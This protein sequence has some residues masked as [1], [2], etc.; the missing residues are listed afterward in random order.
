MIVVVSLVIEVVS[1]EAVLVGFETE[2][3]VAMDWTH[4]Y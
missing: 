1:Q 2:C 4:F 3:L